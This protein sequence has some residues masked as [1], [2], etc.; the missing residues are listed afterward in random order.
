MVYSSRE[1]IVVITDDLGEETIRERNRHFGAMFSKALPGAFRRGESI[2]SRSEGA[3]PFDKL[4]AGSEEPR[5][6]SYAA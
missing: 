6:H 1:I 5:F 4:R 2:G 3:A